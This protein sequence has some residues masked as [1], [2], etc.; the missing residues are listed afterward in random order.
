M[1]ILILYKYTKLRIL[2]WILE[3]VWHAVLVFVSY[4]ALLKSPYVCTYECKS[5]QDLYK[6]LIFMYRMKHTYVA[7]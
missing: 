5:V 1:L 7:S 4:Y 2:K 3:Q 6:V